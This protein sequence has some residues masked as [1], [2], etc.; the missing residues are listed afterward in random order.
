[1]WFKRRKKSEQNQALS[2]S[3][4]S[5]QSLLNETG[6]REPQLDAAT[7]DPPKD[8]PAGREPGL[9]SGA[10]PRG[11]AEAT[12]GPGPATPE[13]EN[14]WR[15]LRLSFDA[16]PVV[17]RPAGRAGGTRKAAPP[18]HG[19]RAGD[20]PPPGDAIAAQ[21]SEAPG[22]GAA[23][24]EAPDVETTDVEAP[25]TEAPEAEAPE[26]EASDAE[27]SDAE[28]SDAEAP[29]AEAPE[30]EAPE[31][32]APEAEA[33]DAEDVE[34]R[35]GD[36]DPHAGGPDV[37]AR[38]AVQG[39]DDQRVATTAFPAPSTPATHPEAL[40]SKGENQLPLQLEPT[41]AP[42]DADIPVLTQPLY[43]PDAPAEAAPEV[44][45]RATTDHGDLCHDIE[46]LRERLQH[47]DLHR[48]SPR[49]QAHLH[50]RLKALLDEL[51]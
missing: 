42:G 24:T 50:E 6:R 47:L 25:E 7:E 34:V 27:A 32:E 51:Q 39:G 11:G 49:H 17:A 10:E 4:R 20:E 3:L 26:A 18:P 46:A 45:G 28:A 1:M 37:A 36:A 41:E 40:S 2:Q 16:E 14:R 8:N 33:P 12:A 35:H 43:V 5:L 38:G 44:P 31:A 48:L 13:A 15:G 19:S 9:P 23:D 30:A 29:D 21:V 22:V